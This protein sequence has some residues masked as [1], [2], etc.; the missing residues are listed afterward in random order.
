MSFVKLSQIYHHQPNAV[1]VSFDLF[2]V[3]NLLHLSK[4]LLSKIYHFC[5]H[6]KNL[7]FTIFLKI[8]ISEFI[9]LGWH[10]NSPF[11]LVVSE[12]SNLYLVLSNM[13]PLC[14]DLVIL[15]FL[16]VVEIPY[17]LF[18]WNY[19]FLVL[20]YFLDFICAQYH[21]WSSIFPRFFFS[22]ITLQTILLTILKWNINLLDLQCVLLDFN[23]V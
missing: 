13:V 10:V 16:D 11:S 7:Y 22:V 9:I 17:L 1:F 23:N 20:I 19:L 21:I 14:V 5:L 12:N 2:F 4:D 15:V 3:K 18:L 8:S 6:I